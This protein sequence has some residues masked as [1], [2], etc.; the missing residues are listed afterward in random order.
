MTNGTVE[1]AIVVTKTLVLFFGVL[2]TY[3]SFRASRRTGSR[4]LRDL[5]IGFAVVTVG[6]ALGGVA[7]QVFDVTFSTGVLFQSLLTALGFAIITY[8]LYTD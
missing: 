8:S 5:S 6:A 7:N 3:L 4:P 2:I 1:A